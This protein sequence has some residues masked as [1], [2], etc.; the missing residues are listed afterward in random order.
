MSI[1]IHPGKYMARIVNYGLRDS[2]NNGVMALVEM[3]Y[4]DSEGDPHR[5]LWRGAFAGQ[6]T[7]YTLKTLLIC[8][9]D[10]DVSAMADGP[11]SGVLNLQKDLMITVE[12][13]HYEGKTYYRIA[14]IN[15]PGLSNLLSR[16]EAAQRLNG[17][18]IQGEL[19]ALRKATGYKPKPE[20]KLDNI[21]F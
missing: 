14:W 8:G 16:A 1:E 15:E 5:V 3:E 11:E 17:M 4:K 2:K 6:A 7:Q 12:P 9:L 20:P 18:N 10:R 21:P 13:E 19:A